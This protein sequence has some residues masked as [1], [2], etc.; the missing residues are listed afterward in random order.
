MYGY[1]AFHFGLI[2]LLMEIS[3]ALLAASSPVPPGRDSGTVATPTYLSKR[4]LQEPKILSE[5]KMQIFPGTTK[6][7][8]PPDKPQLDADFHHITLKKLQNPGVDSL[9]G[10]KPP[11]KN[12]VERKQGIFIGDTTASRTTNIIFFINVSNPGDKEKLLAP[13]AE[14][15]LEVD[16]HLEKECGSRVMGSALMGV[17]R[18]LEYLDKTGKPQQMPEWV[19][20]KIYGRYEKEGRGKDFEFEL[21]GIKDRWRLK[22][23]VFEGE[24]PCEGKEGAVCLVS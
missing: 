19:A 20:K 11:S 12:F 7:Y 6:C 2:F 18:T 5:S 9:W 4:L 13:V 23:T 10:S 21:P 14:E 17:V 3:F 16:R 8:S 24:N 15:Y 22:E 1:Q